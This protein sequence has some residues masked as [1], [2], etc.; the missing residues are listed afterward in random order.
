MSALSVTMRRYKSS[1]S[2]TSYQTEVVLNGLAN[3]CFGIGIR[4]V[5]TVHNTI[6]FWTQKEEPCVNQ[7]KVHRRVFPPFLTS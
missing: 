6:S 7:V 2:S 3:G 4:M 5:Q 1:W